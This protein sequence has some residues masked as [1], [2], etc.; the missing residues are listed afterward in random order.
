MG[1]WSSHKVHWRYLPILR[2]LARMPIGSLVSLILVGGT[3]LWASNKFAGRLEA[4]RRWIETVALRSTSESYKHV[5]DRLRDGGLI[6]VHRPTGRVEIRYASS[7]GLRGSGPLEDDQPQPTFAPDSD[8]YRALMRLLWFSEQGEFIR[9]EID[10]W[11]QS[12]QMLAI[13]DNRYI[14]LGR[15]KRGR[16]CHDGKTVPHSYVPQDCFPN[17]WA[18]TYVHNGTSTNAFT[19]SVASPSSQDFAFV[20]EKG[21]S[22]MGAWRVITPFSEEPPSLSSP[23]QTFTYRFST[24]MSLGQQPVLVNLIGDVGSISVDGSLHIIDPKQRETSLSLGRAKVEIRAIPGYSPHVTFPRCLQA[25]ERGRGKAY[26]ISLSGSIGQKIQIDIE[27]RPLSLPIRDDLQCRDGCLSR[28]AH[29]R[30]HCDSQDKEVAWEAPL[31]ARPPSRIPFQIT[32]RDGKMHLT[33]PDSGELETA[34][35]ELGLA[36]VVGLGPV[37]YG[38]LVGGLREANRNA[39]ETVR[40]SID[41]DLQRLT[42]DALS[43]VH[44][45]SPQN[46]QTR[47]GR[48]IGYEG[49]CPAQRAAFVVMDASDD[50]ARRGEILALASW[51]RVAE[52]ISLW[53]LAALEMAA[54]AESPVAGMAWR[55]NDIWATP[56]SSFKL[57]TAAAAIQAAID[58]NEKIAKLL[59]GSIDLKGM[60]NELGIVQGGSTDGTGGWRE[61]ACKPLHPQDPKFLDALPVLARDGRT[62]ARCLGNSA[63]SGPRAPFIKALILPEKSRCAQGGRAR[64]GLCEAL[65]TSSNL[66]FS[67]IA[68]R[69]DQASVPVGQDGSE[70][71]SEKELPQLHM[72]KM[73]RRLFPAEGL[74]NPALENRP[75]Y[76]F[77]LLR[78]RVAG[79]R[80]LVAS[81]LLVAAAAKASRRD[82]DGRA[83]RLQLAQAG[84][85]QSVRATVLAMTSAYASAASGKVVRP[86]VLLR[87]LAKPDSVTDPLEGKDLFETPPGREGVREELVEQLRRGLNGVVSVEGGTARSN[88]GAIPQAVLPYVFAKTG[89]AIVYG[90]EK[91]ILH[92]RARRPPYSAWI[93][94]W[95]EPPGGGSGVNRRL[96]FGCQVTHSYE[97]GGP[98]CGPVVGAFIR[99]LHE[100]RR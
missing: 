21:G 38:S 51:P 45:A 75:C 36:P 69:M 82:A 33:N 66:Y 32:T 26:G 20:A 37:D 100:S 43:H 90:R 41:Q 52:G 93:V 50:E 35:I 76:G 84:I 53:D 94:G 99:A 62:I 98:A 4:N 1:S 23:T 19:G 67:G 11:N 60:A 24:T 3:L 12:Y 91:G 87:E 77:D 47:G 58:G 85:G 79:A 88:V 54:P 78:G 13:R 80:R 39:I 83:R 65:I 34:A 29:L 7:D 5:F 64:I 31:I 92:G 15:G 8:E 57:V 46:R 72:A 16:V 55:A 68:L 10:A 2:A 44:C 95:V 30:V 22:Y 96:A 59:R 71:E 9:K 18:S 70:I 63:E 61:G 6:W 48:A 56:G 28:S 73:A 42:I 17:E 81:T 49:T 40:L 89:T 86:R 14:N 25:G 97:Y 27:A 74:C